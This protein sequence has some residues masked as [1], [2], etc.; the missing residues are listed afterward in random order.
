MMTTLALPTLSAAMSAL[1]AEHGLCF[2][3]SAALC[4]DLANSYVMLGT[5]RAAT[6]EERKTIPGASP[7]PFI[8]CWVELSGLVLAP[9][10]IRAM[11]GQLI[12]IERD[13]YYAA[14]AATN[15]HAIPR[16]VVQTLGLEHHLTTGEPLPGG[17]AVGSILA[18]VAAY[19]YRVSERGTM[20]PDG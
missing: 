7:V 2:H 20:L 6:D 15:V 19:P 3:Y 17:R 8:H 18:D 5:F 16:F 11:G 4:L 9:T 13:R 14:N 1:D 12:P 10:L